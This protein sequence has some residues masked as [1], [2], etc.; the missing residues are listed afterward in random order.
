MDYRCSLIEVAKNVI[1]I[2]AD[3]MWIRRVFIIMQAFE[4]DVTLSEADAMLPFIET[5]GPLISRHVAPCTRCG[6]DAS[7]GSGNLPSPKVTRQ[8]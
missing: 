7:A 6:Q 8:K 2:D 3:N 1:L 5:V 4:L